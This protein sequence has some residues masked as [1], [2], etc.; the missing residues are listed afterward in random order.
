M[1]ID[2][3]KTASM[4]ELNQL[5]IMAAFDIGRPDNRVEYDIWYSSSSDRMLDFISDFA[6]LD[7]K[8]GDTVLMTPRFRFWQCFECEKDFIER[9]CFGNG[10]YCAHDSNHPT[11]PGRDII[12]E[13]LRQ[14]CVYEKD[15]TSKKTR[16]LWWDYII[17]VHEECYGGVTKECSRLAHKDLGMSFDITNVCVVNSFG[18]TTPGK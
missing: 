14:M 4:E 1:I 2:F 10:K 11:I 18:T 7:T 8:F 16:G 15:Y 17:N 5:A 13:D 12:L 3:L 9:N 6:H